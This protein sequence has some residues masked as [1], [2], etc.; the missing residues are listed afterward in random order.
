MKDNQISFHCIALILI[1]SISYALS[2]KSEPY[3]W[4]NV[5]TGA[6]GGF[7][8][9]IIFNNK[10]KDLIYARTDIGGA[11]RWDPTAKH[12]IPL[13]DFLSADDWNLFGV[14]SLA[15]DPVDPKRV[16]IAAG[17]YTNEWSPTN[18]EILRSTDMGNTWKRTKLPFKVGGNMPGRSMG[19]R[20]GIDPNDNKII[21]FGARSGHGLWKST[22]Y[23]ETFSKV[24]SFTADGKYVEKEGN[25]YTNDTDGEVWVVFDPKSGSSGK[26]SQS[27]Y[28]GTADKEK[29]VF[30]SKDGG[31][32]W[33]AV[34]GQP[35]GFL[36]HHGVLSSEGI[37]YI[38]YSN[39]AGPYDGTKGEVWKLD[40][41]TGTWTNISPVKSDSKDDFF[42][43]GGLSV[44]AKNPKTVMVAALNSWWPD[45][46]FFRTTDGG[47]TWTRIWD[48]DG[49]PN[50]KLRYQMDIS[51]A[52][53]L[54]FGN[55]NPIPPN[56]SVRLGWMVGALVIDPHNSDHMLYGTG[57]T[58]YGT[59]DLTNWDKNT[60]FHIN[61]RA[62]GIEETSVTEVISPS[63]GA[64]LYSTMGDVSGFRHDDLDKAPKEMYS[65]PYAGTYS[66]M[67]FAELKPDFMVRVGYGK[68]G[69]NPP[70]R[71]SGF[72]YDS[73]ANW[74]QGNND[75][76]GMG[77][78]GGTVA[79]AADASRVIWSPKTGGVFYS[80]DNGN[81]WHSSTG[82]GPEGRVA[83]DRVNPKKFYGYAT[84][85][86]HV[87]TDSG[88]TFKATE[89]LDLVNS[90]KAVPGHEGEIWLAAGKNGL[91]HSKDSGTSFTKVS[92]VEVAD[93]IGFGKAK[94]GSTYPSI[95]VSAI[96]DK[97]HA[98]Y[99]SDDKAVT[100][101]HIN[102]KTHQ[103]G[104]VQCI[105]GD[106]RVY[107]RVYF[108]TN[109]RGIIYGNPK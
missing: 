52:P 38:T 58:I 24:T 108:G 72:S 76:K 83:S 102:D 64:H 107:G 106:S 71:S 82:I 39:G 87:S 98:I 51:A 11:Y 79:A 81:S 90:F 27:I 100:W 42:G 22:D 99:R 78:G 4:K 3:V 86:F 68:P 45:E 2:A 67:D 43:Y 16:Y 30:H 31:K 54:N 14:D 84:G 9:G 23:G 41:K 94:T 91:Y 60:T 101:V 48:W 95:Y 74:F 20:L 44:D 97:V 50:R 59:D 35:T 7:V 49:Y 21:Y 57:A 25:S 56:P 37:L 62:A 104:T 26:P 10:Q 18:G 36:P 85:S 6:G 75:P 5:V 19:E 28:V 63:K 105:T 34:E 8:P 40:T 29:S 92:G 73:G 33:A 109:G 70:I 53:W 77:E 61:V 69:E 55:K 46:I 66:H 17:T 96:I 32:T 15:S 47:A 80:T 103:Y 88:V 89:K 93:Q 13:L 65:I 1:L 12:W